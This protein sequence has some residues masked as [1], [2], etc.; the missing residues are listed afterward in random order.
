LFFGELL[1][2]MIPDAFSVHEPDVFV[3]FE[4]RTVDRIREFGFWNMVIGRALGRTGARALSEKMM[5]QKIDPAA[6]RQWVHRIRDRYYS[7][8]DALLVIESNSQWY[9][10][11][12]ALRAAYLDCK[13]IGVVRDPRSWVRSWINEGGRHDQRDRV[14]GYGCERLCPA[15]VGDEAYAARWKS[16]DTF[17]KLCWEWKTLYREIDRFVAGA[18]NAMMFRFEDLFLS[19]TSRSHATE[20]LNFI[21]TWPE[22]TYHFELNESSWAK[23]VNESVPSRLDEWRS[24]SPNRARCLQ[25]ICRGRLLKSY[26]YCDEPE[27]SELLHR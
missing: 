13:I 20:L 8:I 22:R 25:E 1:G 4:R 23:P 6:A 18:Q 3:G 17:A 27:W 21:C 10:A 9:G 5:A 12:P 24:W 7:A 16:M 11:L 2:T 19:A 14:L 15:M 26:G